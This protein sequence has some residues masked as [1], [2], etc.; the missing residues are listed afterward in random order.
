MQHTEVQRPLPGSRRPVLAT[1]IS[2]MLVSLG[3]IASPAQA[4]STRPYLGMGGGLAHAE[5]GSDSETA[6]GMQLLA[7]LQF[8]RNFA[9]EVS[10]L[11]T[12]EYD[13]PGTDF[14]LSSIGA[15][16]LFILPL[17]LG[18]RDSWAI[19]GKLGLSQTSAL[20]EGNDGAATVDDFG[21]NYGLGV[22]YATSRNFA[23]RLGRDSRPYALGRQS[24]DVSL[25]TLSGI[26]RF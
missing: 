17:G 8:N 3:C 6:P 2:A 18:S 16:G 21:L 19:Y 10:Y 11:F 22:Q 25:T 24:N 14:S 20:Y 9:V 13:S 12:T 4:Q 1:A 7:G 23:L 5:I 15:A 26:L